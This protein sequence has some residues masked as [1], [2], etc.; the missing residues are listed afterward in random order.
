M[1]GYM[2]L[3]AVLMPKPDQIEVTAGP[4][5]GCRKD[6]AIATTRPAVSTEPALGDNLPGC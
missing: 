4:R 5:S 2:A 6:R 3:A 1:K